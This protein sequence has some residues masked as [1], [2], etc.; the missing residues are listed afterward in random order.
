[1]NGLAALKQFSIPECLRQ[2]QSRILYWILTICILIGAN[3]CQKD[4]A[5]SR[6]QTKSEATNSSQLLGPIRV[7]SQATPTTGPDGQTII[8]NL[9]AR[10]ATATTYQDQAVLYLNYLMR[11]QR[12]QEPQP[13]ATSFQRGSSGRPPKLAAQ[14]FNGEV[15]SDQNLLSCYIYD[16]ESANLDNQNLLIPFENQLP[17]NQLYRDSIAKYF[18]GGY[19]ELPLD[20]TDL[21][22]TPKL[23]PAPISLLT[24]QVRNGW[25][26]NPTQVQRMADQ[27]LDKFEC[28]VVRCM[29]QGM[30]ADVWVDKKTNTLRQMSL[31]LKLL[32]GEVIVSPEITDVVLM[33]K[34]HDAVIDTP[35]KAEAFS[36][37]TKTDSTA[38]RKFVQLPESLPSDLIGKTAPDF[39][40][41]TREGE[42]RDRL[43]F[44]GKVTALLW[45]AGRHSYDAISKLDSL[46]QS[47]DETTFH[48]ASVYSDSELVAPG[49]GASTVGPELTEV[50]SQIQ[51]PVYYDPQLQASTD[52]GIKA[53][54]S[55][56]VLDGNSKIQFARALSDKNWLDD[57]KAAVRRVAAGDDV[58]S[59]MQAE[60]VRYLDSYHQQLATVSAADLIGPEKPGTAMIAS[61]GD[62]RIFAIRLKPKQEWVNTEFKQAG[63][64]A[65]MNSDL[66]SEL[67]NDVAYSIFDGWRTIVEVGQD[68]KTID[69]IELKLPVGEAGNLI[70]VGGDGGKRMTAVFATLGDK[71]Y[72]YDQNWHQILVYPSPDLQHQGIRDCRLTDLNNDGVSELAVAFDGTEGIHL[73]DPKTGQGSQISKSNSTSM[74]AS[75]GDI[76]VAGSGKIATLKTGLT[77][78]GESELQFKRVASIGSQHLCGIGVTENGHWNAVGF[79]EQLK[80]IWTLS[81][82]SQFFESQLEP[83]TATRIGK[84]QMT[85]VLWAIADTEDVIHLV[86]G[87][88]KWL[89]DFQSKSKIG[90]VGLDSRNGK[91]RLIVCNQTG[92]ECWDLNLES[93]SI[94][95]RAASTISK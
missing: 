37:Q 14:L 85:E 18:I 59:E 43:Y 72:L 19:S 3:G 11:G 7:P 82:G 88:G 10:Y 29:S 42:T 91:T 30:T 1:M 48:L 40:I 73:V 49:T 74:V 78:V 57:V 62:Q 34:F 38:V 63:N 90:G 79:D 36:L 67:S 86:S 54:P 56:I 12:I 66:Q 8:G 17:I 41:L 25:L 58:A 27:T 81:I 32:A 20:E 16:I 5:G 71:V 44:D 15:R 70:R 47:L 75:G 23:I 55:V 13:W 68:G 28:Y 22:S 95:V 9:V 84:G 80:R 64:V 31:P 83:I 94:P 24:N 87:S 33:A 46:A 76:V 69:R 52:L 92:V 61:A 35:I 77:N 39:R 53:I 60:Y 6:G 2:N 89:G 4:S 51:T 26:Q 50:I 21:A 93:S 65:V 45:I